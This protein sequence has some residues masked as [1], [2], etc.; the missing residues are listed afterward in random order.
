[1][2]AYRC[3]SHFRMV[4]AFSGLPNSDF[5]LFA[6]ID[7]DVLA[8]CKRLERGVHGG[9]ELQTGKL[10]R[11]RFDAVSLPR[12]FHDLEMHDVN[13]AIGVVGER[14]GVFRQVNVRN[15][16]YFA[17]WNRLDEL[18]C[19]QIDHSHHTA[20]VTDCGVISGDGE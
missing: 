15:G 12:L 1:M 4:L 7:A 10:A 16:L 19:F 14:F 11:K 20:T 9:E 6:E 5:V 17:A 18:L 3:Q 13:D 8:R 2:A